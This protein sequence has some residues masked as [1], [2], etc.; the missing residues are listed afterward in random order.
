MNQMH[1]HMLTIGEVSLNVR[2]QGDP[3]H[4]AIVFLH[5]FPEYSAMWTKVMAALSNRFYCI[6]PDQRGYATSSKP[7]GI[8]HYTVPEL[9][10]DIVGLI[11][12]V[13]AG[14]PV[15]LVGHDWGAAVA[16]AVAM[17]RP[18]LIADLVIINGI[19]AA[20]FQHALL[21]DPVQ[22]QSSQYFHKLR[23]PLAAQKLSQDDFALM[24]KF[25]ASFS[26]TSWMT[27]EER[28]GYIWAWGQPGAVDAMLNWYRASP[29]Y[30]PKDGEDLSAMEN[31]FDDTEKFR[32]RPRHML[33][34]G[35]N[36]HALRPSSFARLHEFCDDLT[37]RKIADADHWVVSARP[38]QVI[39]AL[40]GFLRD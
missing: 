26:D 32:V 6:A 40:A 11:E 23:H 34:W 16:Y 20:A 2:F 37:V 38:D 35:M 31:P 27:E 18:D 4:P 14:R 29:I 8:E 19:H 15:H 7:E 30:V 22:V 28:Q 10:G 1:Q 17:K 36:D 13:S 12:Q 33:I 25:F 9:S 5:G 3:E 21:T 39:N 24:F